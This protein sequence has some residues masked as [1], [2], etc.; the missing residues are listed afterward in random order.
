MGV[1]HQL[2]TPAALLQPQAVHKVLNIGLVGPQSQ[3]ERFRKKSH[4]PAGNRTILPLIYLFF[5]LSVLLVSFL[6]T[7]TSYFIVPLSTLIFF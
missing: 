7:F 2:L 3:F 4:F 6:R 1:T 5:F